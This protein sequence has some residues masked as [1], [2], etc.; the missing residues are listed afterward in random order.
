MIIYREGK[1]I[2]LTKLELVDAF[3]EQQKLNYRTDIEEKIESMYEEG[4][5]DDLDRDNIDID[6]AVRDMPELISNNDDY[7]K[8][9]WSTIKQAID[10]NG[11]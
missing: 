2:E 10:Q 11:Y 4:M 8:A 3:R 7:Y 5:I 1:A 6:A 9:Y